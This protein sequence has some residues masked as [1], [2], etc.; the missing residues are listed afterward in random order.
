MHDPEFETYLDL[1]SRFLRLSGRQREEIR[2]E[3]RAHLDEALQ[4]ANERGEPA[5]AALRRVLSDFGDAAAL[6]ARFQYSHR[7]RRWIMNA[8]LSA[9]CIAFALVTTT[10]FDPQT[11]RADAA[12]LPGSVAEVVSSQSNQDVQIRAALQRVIADV[13]LNDQPLEQALQWL[14][15][16][17]SVNVHIQWNLLQNAGVNRDTIIN[18]KV[19]GL[20]VERVLRLVFDEIDGGISYA[21]QDGVL[22]ISTPEQ[23]RKHL[24]TEVYDV[25]ELIAMTEMNAAAQ[26][27][28]AQ[29]ATAKERTDNAATQI[30]PRVAAEGA[31][32]VYSGK[33][34]VAQTADD[35]FPAS[36]R[37]VELVTKMV[38]PD[39]WDVN[40]GT[41]SIEEFNGVLV[42]RQYDMVHQQVR[43]LLD[44]LRSTLLDSRRN[45]TIVEPGIKQ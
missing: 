33:S 18:C 31:N 38:S 17:M 9:A 27:R 2:R 12:R 42:I 15:S 6:A 23:L 28:R 19:K 13:Q 3:L 20:S 36:R 44:S 29:A 4:E 14:A 11:Q 5:H 30:E 37:V 34:A 1:L 39:T 25:R 32:S 41:A 7:R 21:V 24:K 8:T 40:G 22:L 35:E 16:T 45:A 26:K 43:E 10:F